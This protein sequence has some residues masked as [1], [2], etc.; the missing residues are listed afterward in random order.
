MPAVLY[1]FYI[2]IAICWIFTLIAPALVIRWSSRNR[3]SR[4]LIFSLIALF[5]AYLGAARFFVTST[6]T[7]NDHT[8]EYDSRRFFMASLALCAVAFGWTIWKKLRS[9]NT[10]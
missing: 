1:I 8:T 10:A 5:V 4:A 3:F 6:F 9:R 7:K 2:V